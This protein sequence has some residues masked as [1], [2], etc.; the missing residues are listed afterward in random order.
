[1]EPVERDEAV[2]ND[3]SIS[4]EIEVL[5]FISL[6]Q[7]KIIKPIEEIEKKSGCSFVDS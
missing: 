1:M 6:E 3:A 5:Y 2:K 7:I 4:I